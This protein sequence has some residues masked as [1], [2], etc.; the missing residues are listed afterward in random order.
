MLVQKQ[1]AWT[2]R[3]LSIQRKER[4][5]EWA[6]RRAREILR[7]PLGRMSHRKCTYCEYYFGRGS[8]LEIEHYISRFEDPNRVFEWTNLLPACQLCN[9]AKLAKVHGGLL[10]KPDEE[11]PESFFS[12]ESA[13]GKLIPNPLLDDDQQ[14]RASAT[15]KLCD[16]NRGDLMEIRLEEMEFV[17][18]LIARLARAEPEAVKDLEACLKPSKAY[19]FVLRHTLELHGQHLLAQADR[20]RFHA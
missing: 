5:G 7:D 11:D 19:K 17:G 9:G 8:R 13:T 15:I 12:L 3:W 16:L 1:R 14:E 20:D 6:T 10:V 18:R 4:K 2:E